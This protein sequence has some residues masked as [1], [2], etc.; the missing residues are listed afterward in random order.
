MQLA[1]A[2]ANVSAQQAKLAELKSGAKPED[3]ALAQTAVVNA[4]NSLSDAKDNLS[5]V[6]GNADTDISNEYSAVKDILSDASIK[7]SDAITN[8]IHDIFNN[9][10][11]NGP[12]LVFLSKDSQNS[13]IVETQ[14]SEIQQS[15]SQLK[16]QLSTIPGDPTALD[17][18]LVST[19]TQLHTYNDFLLKL[20]DSVNMA[21]ASA[22]VSQA[23]VDIFKA[24]VNAALNEVQAAVTAIDNQEQ[25]IA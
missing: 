17:T 11:A 16:S 22:D 10:A 23:E 19:E 25:V 1:Q 4:Q 20:Q 2:Q 6:Q 9:D 21:I 8:K 3:I 7:A 12:K 13:S 5:S 24:N 15:L 14:E 18:L